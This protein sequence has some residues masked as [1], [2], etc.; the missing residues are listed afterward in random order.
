MSPSII[1]FEIL[2]VID[3][4]YGDVSLKKSKFETTFK[5]LA[6]EV[7]LLSDKSIR[8]LSASQKERFE[9]GIKEA[10]RN[11][12]RENSSVFTYKAD[13][14]KEINVRCFFDTFSSNK[15]NIKIYVG[16]PSV[17]YTVLDTIF[18]NGYPPGYGHYLLVIEN[19]Q[20][21]NFQKGNRM[22]GE[23]KEL[24]TDIKIL[25]YRPIFK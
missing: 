6:K 11:L 19:D 3:D 13:L 24:D 12:L 15:G 21:L 14:T 7:G 16:I 2:T 20:S 4:I 9:N 1:T 8:T 10:T 17:E 22:E 18:K 5:N 23:I 25:T